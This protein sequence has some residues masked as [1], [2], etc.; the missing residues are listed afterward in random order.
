MYDPEYKYGQN[1]F[2]C[3]TPDARDSFIA[4]EEAEAAAEA[5]AEAAEEQAVALA[6]KDVGL[7]RLRARLGFVAEGQGHRMDRLALL[8]AEQSAQLDAG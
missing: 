5:E 8:R 6:Q 2:V 3:L 1:F 4:S 7:A